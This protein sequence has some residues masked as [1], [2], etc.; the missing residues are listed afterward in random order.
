MTEREHF[1]EY[2]YVAAILDSYV[3][4][5]SLLIMHT[6]DISIY[7]CFIVSVVLY[8]I[9]CRKTLNI[10]Y[11]GHQIQE[12]QEELKTKLPKKKSRF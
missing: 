2:W 10:W 12:I 3:L 9:V 8:I 5:L 6:M 7:L 11:I 4:G 1:K